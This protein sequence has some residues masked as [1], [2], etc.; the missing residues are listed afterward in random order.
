MSDIE[1]LTDEKKEKVE[2][3]MGMAAITDQETAVSIL[4]SVDWNL[5]RAVSTL[6][7]GD[8]QI[9]E[10]YPGY[11]SSNAHDE[12]ETNFERCWT[13]MMERTRPNA[14][15]VSNLVPL[16]PKGFDSVPEALEKFGQVFSAR[17]GDDQGN[18]PT[19]ST[20][21]LP[22]AIRTAFEE[23]TTKPLF[24]YVHNDRSNKADEFASEILCHKDVITVLNEKFIV[25]PWDATDKENFKHLMQSLYE[26]DIKVF[27][28]VVMKAARTSPN[29]FPVFGAI[30][31]Y[32]KKSNLLGVFQSGINL[33]RTM[34]KLNALVEQFNRL[35]CMD[36]IEK[37]ESV[38]RQ[39][40]RAEQEAEY[41][42]S[43]AAD[44]AKIEKK[45]Q[46]EETERLKK[47]AEEEEAEK[48]RIAEEKEMM[49][50]E[51]VLE[52]L[53][54]EPSASETGIIL[55][56]FR[57]PKGKQEIRRFRQSET[58]ETMF[59]F[60]SGKGFPLSEYKVLNSD[61]PRKNISDVLDA[62]NTFAELNWHSREQ[63]FVE[64]L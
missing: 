35:K 18:V 57:L 22:V 62:R 43:L 3:Y 28:D 53:P 24:F 63:V 37:Q 8:E 41:Q 49:R 1:P 42:A 59:D 14:P 56:K 17:Y 55:I 51:K 45:K 10:D 21:A 30:T 50:R 46:E 32:K 60:L 44:M 27:A 40:L 31:K 29:N 64:E 54:D 5:Q 39:N 12:L 36:T 34:E 2:Q 61:F 7:D 26:Y 48:Q 52:N 47:L 15:D 6:F 13:S 11:A 23:E 58:L 38:Q 9:V 33:E 16:I 19:F 25:F 20:V 4:Q